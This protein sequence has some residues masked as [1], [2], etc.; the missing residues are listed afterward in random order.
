MRSLVA[1]LFA[2]L[3]LSTAASARQT[4]TA[5]DMP[6][7]FEPPLMMG[8]GGTYTVEESHCGDN[9]I[10]TWSEAPPIAIIFISLTHNDCV[11]ADWDVFRRDLS[12][13]FAFFRID[14]MFPEARVEE[15]VRVTENDLGRIEYAIGQLSDA[16][17]M[18]CVIFRQGFGG[19][20]V[21][22]RQGR[23][24]L[25]GFYCLPFAVDEEYAKSVAQS[26][27][28]NRNW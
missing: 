22:A 13:V 10:A 25:I 4:T 16:A 9:Y 3:V 8:G 11:A 12:R 7:L 19:M 17:G 14:K 18:A 23:D 5:T 21:N 2:V 15:A 20:D 1:G 26:L 28:R 24:K 27:T 6:I